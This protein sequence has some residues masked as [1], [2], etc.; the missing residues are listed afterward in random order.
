LIPKHL[1][2]GLLLLPPLQDFLGRPKGTRNNFLIF[3]EDHHLLVLLDRGPPD[4]PRV[5]LDVIATNQD[6]QAIEDLDP[7]LP[8][9]EGPR[10]PLVIDNGLFF[11]PLNFKGQKRLHCFEQ[12]VNLMLVYRQPSISL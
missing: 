1:L 2:L 5:L 11:F 9:T 4:I 7:L 12:E 3:S 8:D 6:L 10:L